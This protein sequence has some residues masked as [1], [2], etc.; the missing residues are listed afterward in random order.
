[1][2]IFDKPPRYRSN[3]FTYWEDRGREPDAPVVWRF[4]LEDPHSGQRHGFASLDELVTVLKQEMVE[5]D[6]EYQ[7]EP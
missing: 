4:S 5:S 6:N 3:L 7:D 1:M 2:A